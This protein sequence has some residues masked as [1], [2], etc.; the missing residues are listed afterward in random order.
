MCPPLHPEELLANT[1]SIEI[2]SRDR[3][4]QGTENQGVTPERVIDFGG[5]ASATG[6]A[7]D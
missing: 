6:H 3:R 7:D 2:E 5:V 1:L 4:V